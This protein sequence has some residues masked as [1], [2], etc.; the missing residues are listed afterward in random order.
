MFRPL[1][2]TNTVVLTVSSFLLIFCAFTSHGADLSHLSRVETTTHKTYTRVTISFS[3]AV[4]CQIS[5]DNGRVLIV[6]DGVTAPIGKITGFRSDRRIKAITTCRRGSAL[7]IVISHEKAMQV[8]PLQLVPGVIVID[9]GALAEDVFRN[10]PPERERIWEGVEKFIRTFT[11]P[12]VS[13]LPF[14]PTDGRL[15]QE[16]MDEGERKQFLDGE[17]A[18]YRG[19]ASEAVEVFQRFSSSNKVARTLALWRLGEAYYLVQEY[20]KALAAFGAA[21]SLTPNEMPISPATLFFYADTVARCGNF[22]EGRRRM[23]RLVSRLAETQQAPFLL[24]RLGEMAAREG[25]AGEAEFIWESIGARFPGHSATKHAALNLLDQKLLQLDQERM[26][27]QLSVLKDIYTLTEDRGLK[28]EALFKKSLLLALYGTA[29]DAI[30]T[31]REY[32]GTYPQGVF[33]TIVKGMHEE[34]VLIRYRELSRKG[35]CD[36]VLSLVRENRDQLSA[37]LAESGFAK[38]VSACFVSA[39]L[40]EEERNLFANLVERHY[41]GEQEPFLYYRMIEDDF[42]LADDIHAQWAC[43]T[44]LSRFPRDE[45]AAEVLEKRAQLAFEKRD[46]VTTVRLLAPS[47]KSGTVSSPMNLYYLGKARS[48]LRDHRGAEMAMSLLIE[49]PGLPNA[50]VADAWAVRAAA[51]E[52]M[53]DMR[54]ALA[55]YE[56]GLQK[57]NGNGADEF[58]YKIGLTWRRLGNDVQARSYWDRLHL[59]G[60]DPVWRLLAVSG[61]T[62]ITN[63]E[64]VRVSK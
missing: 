27:P 37:S 1:S 58:L 25:R 50:I 18:I 40:Y 28:E 4:S 46:Y 45:H 53:G 62:E 2:V 56:N 48:L 12:L 34:L 9:V 59:G 63:Q 26:A 15:L 33:G 42:F 10:L 43:D 39:G 14:V 22:P 32:E 16:F 61:L 24:V 5:L 38:A 30:D 41:P 11:P 52:A 60:T 54:G 13:R 7:H 8:R 44:Y 23:A 21:E 49:Q 17:E 36:S 57:T 51:R 35:D 47:L 29:E 55:F 6:A 31:V 64:V 3:N 20:R 19:Q